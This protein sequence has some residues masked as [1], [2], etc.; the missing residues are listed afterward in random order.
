MDA[1]RIRVMVVDDSAV[2]RKI[3]TSTLLKEEDIEVVGTAASGREAISRFKELKPDVITLDVEM[4]DMTGIEAIPYIRQI[5]SRVPIIMFS[6]LTE[7]GGKATLDALSAG[8]TDYVTKPSSS[9]SVEASKEIIASSLASKIRALGQKRRR[10]VGA[11]SAYSGSPATHRPV[12][13]STP[14]T[15]F[16]APTASGVRSTSSPLARP[17][18]GEAKAS[19]EQFDGAR[20][21]P[22][23]HRPPSL[24]LIGISTGGPN[25]LGEL[26][27]ALPANL[28]V[29]ILIV[30]HMPATF[31]RLLA[32]RLDAKSKLKVMEAKGGEVPRAGEV[33]IAPG[34]HH[35]VVTTNQRSELAIALDD[36]PPVNS[37]RPSVDTLFH[38]ATRLGNRVMA[39]VMTGMGQDG[40]VGARELKAAGAEI[41]T[42]DEAT[43]VVWGMPGYVTNA[44]LSEQ[45]LPL[46]QI[47]SYIVRRC[48]VPGT[49]D[50]S[51]AALPTNTHAPALGASTS[52]RSATSE[53]GGRRWH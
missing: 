2:I 23:T 45:V 17:V 35:L 49:S 53:I 28:P 8:A 9:T 3:V 39:I 26:L 24:I 15:R 51:P 21:R 33:Y 50:R 14:N 4:P 6:T 5:D 40:Y 52:S 47:A 32:E 25:A 29:P 10:A 46:N 36:S 19:S 41:V 37:C 44:G 16:S 43:S 13:S 30:Q 34:E 31:T 38:S 22:T 7:S 20:F 27:P 11:G 18:A 1:A 42:Q 12:P 48:N